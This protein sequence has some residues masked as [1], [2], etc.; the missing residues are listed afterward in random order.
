[1]SKQRKSFI[2]HNDSLNI[3]DELTN[4][5]AGMLFKAIKDY[6]LGNDLELDT[7][8]KVAFSPFKN[9]FERDAVKYENL[10]EKNRLIAESR[11]A[12]KSTTGK[13]GNQTLPKATKSTDNDSDSDS[14]SD[15]KNK[16]IVTTKKYNFSDV[17]FQCAE[18]IYSLVL[19]V[20]PSSKKPNLESWANVIRLMRETDDLTHQDISDVF[21]WA[22]KDSF[23]SVNILS[24]TKL[25]K[26]F[27]QLQAKMKG[28]SNEGTQGTGKKLSAYERARAANAEYRQEQPNEGEVVVGADDGYLGRTVDEGAGRAA[29]LDVDN[30]TFIDY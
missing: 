27:P 21:T 7:L 14:K 22:N 18:W 1:M 9:Q 10:C 2:V 29:L 13:A 15:S 8:T 3:L 28:A 12:T 17:D 11:Y 30:G 26:Q 16:E 25:R 20:A 23:W 4:D 19:N 6:Q 24:V 5:Q